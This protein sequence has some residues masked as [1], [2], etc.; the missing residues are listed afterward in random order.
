MKEELQEKTITALTDI[1]TSVTEAKDFVLAELPEV[2]HQLLMWEL[3]SSILDNVVA[4][5]LPIILTVVLL[6]VWCKPKSGTSNHLWSYCE[7]S[8]RHHFKDN[9]FCSTMFIISATSSALTLMI[10]LSSINTT[11]IKIW[12]APK[13]FLIEYAANLV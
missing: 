7:E 11:F 5:V 3:C 9:D 4:I 8:D 6:K 13:L 1:L 2:I 12:L 10:S